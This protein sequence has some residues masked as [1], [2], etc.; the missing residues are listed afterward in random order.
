MLTAPK[1]KLGRVDDISGVIPNTNTDI[2]K[3]RRKGW[4]RSME[5]MIMAD[6]TCLWFTHT[7]NS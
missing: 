4:H 5:A 6:G 1:E 3:P 2:K 7:D